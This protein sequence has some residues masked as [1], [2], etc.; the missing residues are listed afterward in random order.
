MAESTKKKG[1]GQA[2]G[3]NAKSVPK[4]GTGGKTRQAQ[5]GA[6]AGEALSS[7]GKSAEGHGKPKSP[8]CKKNAGHPG[9]PKAGRQPPRER[10][11]EFECDCKHAVRLS[12]EG[13][14]ESA[15][16]WA[17]YWAYRACAANP[18][19]KGARLSKAWAG[20][21]QTRTC[22]KAAL[23]ALLQ[24][25]EASCFWLA[26]CL[27]LPGTC[28]AAQCFENLCL[29]ELGNLRMGVTPAEAVL[30]LPALGIE[31]ATH[32][33]S[34]RM[35]LT[36]P[37]RRGV[38]RAVAHVVFDSVGK[39]A[40]H[41]L[42]VI[43]L[44]EGTYRVPQEAIVKAA[45]TIPSKVDAR[46][47]KP[48]KIDKR[49]GLPQASIWEVL[50]D[51]CEG[52]PE[53]ED[54]PAESPKKATKKNVA[55]P[56]HADKTE[57]KAKE[58]EVPLICGPEAPAHVPKTEPT[59]AHVGKTEQPPAHVVE[60]EQSGGDEAEALRRAEIA[61]GK[62][63]APKPQEP[64]GCDLDDDWCF[65]S[66]TGEVLTFSHNPEA[67]SSTN[68]ANE[69]P[70]KERKEPNPLPEPVVKA[71]DVNKPPL[72]FARAYGKTVPPAV[73]RGPCGLATSWTYGDCPESTSFVERSETN[74]LVLKCLYKYW[75]MT[76]PRVVEARMGVI[77]VTPMA[78]GDWL[79]VPLT[80][81][82]VN[83]PR[84][85]VGGCL[86]LTEMTGVELHGKNHPLG[87]VVQLVAEGVPIMLRR[88]LAPRKTPFELPR[89]TRT[90]CTGRF[91][92]HKEPLD[93]LMGNLRGLPTNEAKVRLLY[94][95]LKRIVPEECQGLLLEQRG[96]H[97]GLEAVE[98]CEPKN[99]AIAVCDVEAAVRAHF[100]NVPAFATRKTRH[101]RNCVSC[102]VEPPKGKYR[103]PR[104]ICD[105]CRK[106][107]LENGFVCEAGSQVQRN[108]QVP[109]CY[110]GIVLVSG[111]EYP[112]PQK[113]WDRVE[114]ENLPNG[115]GI[116][117]EVPRLKHG[118]KQKKPLR[119]WEQVV[120]SDLAKLKG[121]V[122]KRPL[123]ALAG[124]ACSGAMPMVSAQ[125]DH[126]RLK[127]LAGRVFQNPP[128]KEWGTGPRPGIWEFAKTFIP[129]I[130]P[131][132]STDDMAL[133]E[134]LRSMP[135]RRRRVLEKAAKEYELVGLKKSD[136][137]FKAF[138]KA[139]FLPGFAQVRVGGA[140]VD[141][142]LQELEEMLDRLI[143]A[144]AEKTHIVAGRKLKP[145][146][147]KLKEQW[148][149]YAPLVYGSAGPE[150]LDILLQRLAEFDGT[151]FDC[152]FSLFD[153]THSVQTWDFLESL[154]ATQD[155]DLMQ[156]FEWWRA[157]KGRIGPFRYQGPVMNASGR[158]DTALAN[159][160]L[161]GFATTLSAAA[162]FN[163]IR[164]MELSISQL[165]AFRSK[166]V[167]SV[168]GDD[169]IGV[170]PKLSQRRLAEFRALFNENISQFGFVAKLQVKDSLQDCLYLGQR[171]YW[172]SGRWHWGKTIGR[173][174]YKMGWVMDPQARDVMAH[175]TGIADMHNL[176][177]QHVP[178]LSDLARKIAELRV[179]AKRTPVVPDPNKPWEWTQQ[180]VLPYDAQ[181]LDVCAEVYTKL[182]GTPVSRG[183]FEDLIEQ[184]DMIT[185]LPCV[186]DHPLWRLIIAS[187]EL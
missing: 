69:P 15:A 127:A 10:P 18:T 53:G 56:A 119:K 54:E 9:K 164:V 43:S 44:T 40:P 118:R 187:D 83:E 85:L 6:G 73:Q 66:E 75:D 17:G 70:A 51:E 175:I 110:P 115:Q 171:P 161:N 97:L 103:W 113:K 28:K 125:T 61:H 139:E 137:M 165:R 92:K 14:A 169:S 77:D 25:N 47:K 186:L 98:D 181:T 37:K 152:D 100:H 144:P 116:S 123:F 120:K 46:G 126:N 38:C 107:L 5:S 58:K 76:G 173:A 135:A 64:E 67:T 26:A 72:W 154:Y 57:Q 99:V 114:L 151:Y 11:E 68:R 105:Q 81:P 108:L 24:E 167:I 90:K 143:N 159:A 155:R 128:A 78:K 184:I 19:N 45:A 174:T 140:M 63:H 156:V 23:W 21:E 104:R 27:M 39:V 34:G 20:D 41:Y 158:D 168:C 111:T 2:K 185:A 48:A 79:Y 42:P 36:D 153:R 82:Q 80:Q 1:G 12:A 65:I 160:I 84:H 166:S 95:G 183:D 30:W 142:S 148:H 88:I 32:A 141:E 176:C 74:N 13:R 31:F 117:R 138:V 109:T 93:L 180:G 60:T 8:G 170:M 22:C 172:I 131:D 102:G 62:K 33:E 52:S 134:W 106:A 4:P 89:F 101:P 96:L 59:P 86:N 130:L 122:P 146:V 136:R 177:S 124:I 112:A 35:E 129:E 147:K 29:R 162:A 49:T 150:V 149:A 157:P 163:G 50:E 121:D 94:Q 182:S 87:D 7:A 16:C 3:R 132:L 91:F 178:V 133:D 145:K 55:L 179:G 71:V